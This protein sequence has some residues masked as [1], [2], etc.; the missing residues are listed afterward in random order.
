VLLVLVLILVVVLVLV[1]GL[2]LLLPG[3]TLLLLASHIQVAAPVAR[4]PWGCPACLHA[5]PL[6]H[7]C[8]LCW[9]LAYAA[10]LLGRLATVV[11]VKVP[12]PSATRV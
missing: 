11:R 5:A 10:A 8:H 2:L 9:V 4:R 6:L 12:G 7:C 3:G 1:L